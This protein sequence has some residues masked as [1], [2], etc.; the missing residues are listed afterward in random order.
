MSVAE[1]ITRIKEAKENLKTSIN[2][3]LSDSQTKITDE[4]ISSYSTFVDNIEGGVNINDYF[5]TEGLTSSKYKLTQ[6]IKKCP[7]IDMTG[8]TSMYDMFSGC[9]NL[10]SVSF[11]NASNI[12]NFSNAFTN[13]S[14]MTTFPIIDFSKATYLS[15]CFGGCKN[16]VIEGEMDVSSATNLNSTFTNCWKLKNFHLLNTSNVTT[17]QN[18]FQGCSALNNLPMTDFTKVTDAEAAFA[19][20]R[21]DNIEEINFPKATSLNAL[22]QG[23]E[24]KTLR[25]YGIGFKTIMFGYV[26]WLQA[27]DFCK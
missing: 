4:L 27:F 6:L 19:R 9:S 7:P 23:S 12:T 1:E 17:L 2:A 16:M 20:T 3:K 18:T 10:E 24:I 8:M 21:I 25:K 11:L 14:N 26:R 22:F 13:C 5:I 15:F